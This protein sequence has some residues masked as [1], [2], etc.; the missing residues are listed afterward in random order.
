M[1]IYYFLQREGRDSPCPSS[2][3]STTTTHN[4]QNGNGAN[5]SVEEDE[6]D[7]DDQTE[8]ATDIEDIPK[9]S[10]ATTNSNKVVG[11]KKGNSS[12]SLKK[13]GEKQCVYQMVLFF[14]QF[15]Q[16]FMEDLLKDFDKPAMPTCSQEE[17]EPPTAAANN[18]G[19][20]NNASRTFLDYEDDHSAFVERRLPS[21]AANCRRADQVYKTRTKKQFP[22]RICW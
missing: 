15:S 17:Q 22:T 19:A 4:C 3:S 2:S 8:D 14:F 12:L 11:Q 18:N 13:C 10:E 6:D 9:D 5:K 20:N 16:A 1:K 21:S 7:E